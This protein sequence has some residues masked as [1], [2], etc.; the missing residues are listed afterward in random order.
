MV[1]RI[2]TCRIILSIRDIK[3]RPHKITLR[4]INYLLLL[5]LRTYENS[6]TFLFWIPWKFRCAELDGAEVR[7]WN[8][9]P[10]ELLKVLHTLQS[11]RSFKGKFGQ[12][13][14][15]GWCG[16][17]WN[18]EISEGANVS[19]H[20]ARGRIALWFVVTDIFYEACRF[21]AFQFQSGSET[22]RP[23]MAPHFQ[24]V[25]HTSLACLQIWLSYPSSTSVN[26]PFLSL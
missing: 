6:R 22:F 18:E 13:Y 20:C 17:Q 15:E 3:C 1:I 11:E 4:I 19:L 2:L 16:S 25:L 26:R 12:W 7:C 9:S 10:P 8:I 5:D 14:P 23:N 21:W 24:F